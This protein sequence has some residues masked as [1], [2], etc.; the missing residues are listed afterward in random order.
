MEIGTNRPDAMCHYGVASECSAIYD[1]PLKPIQPKL[2][3]AKA[4][5]KPFAIKIEDTKGC[6]RFTARVIRNVK[7]VESP[8]KILDP[9]AI[10][11]HPAVSNSADA[12]N[13]TRVQRGQPTQAYHLRHPP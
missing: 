7:I 3:N 4:A 2:P 8:A 6:L 11:D 9:L 5:A 1:L 13:Y 12:S 10:D